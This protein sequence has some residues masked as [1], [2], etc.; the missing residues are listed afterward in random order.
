MRKTLLAL[1]A[2][3]AASPLFAQHPNIQISADFNPNEP[4]ICLDPKNPAR[5]VAG[6]NLN[7]V[8]VSADTGQ[9][10]TAGQLSSPFGVWGDPVL[11]VDT[12]GAFY[13]LHLSNP[14]VGSWIDRIV[15]QKSVDGGQ[16][17]SPGA[18]MGHNGQKAQDKEWIAVDP[19]T[20]HLYVSWTEFDDYGSASPLDSSRILFSKS[21]DGGLNWSEARQLNE[22]SGDCVDSDNT[23]EGAVPSVGPNGEVYVAWAGPAGLVFDRSLDG[24][25]TWL[26]DDIAVDP[27]P[28]GW[29][30]T[31]PGLQ[32]CNGLPV[33]ACDR[34]GGPDH[35]AIYINWSDQRNGAGDTDVWLTKSTDGG[36]TWSPPR[37]VNNDPA[38]RH[39]FLTWMQVDQATGW[40]WFVFYDRRHYTDLR[41][42]VYMA[43]SRDGGTTFQN[44]KVSE[45]PF[46]PSTGQF[47]GDYNNVT[48]HDNV[49]R[50]MWTRMEGLNTSVWTALI[51]V[52]ALNTVGTGPA[53]EE[54]AF[55]VQSG[56]PNPASDEVWIPFRIRRS[57]AVTL[58]VTDPQG[59][60]LHTVFE[61]R[62]YDYGKYTEH[63]P[64]RELGLP[65]GTYSIVVKGGGKVLA[66][67]VVVR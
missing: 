6:A 21:T 30:Y 20:N 7:N 24:G 47:F 4:S 8:Y 23:T 54:A 25:L 14:P 5:I 27:F 1:A 13:F 17:W 33:T 67:R 52:A 16:S 3:L 2:A 49:V 9:T 53:P 65:G 35:G 40:L 60:V 12:A 58:Q 29:D 11:G 63:I 37:R 32:R 61:N 31:V 36:Q 28:G 66:R 26:A 19:A 57:T 42:D 59:R 10:W 55:S 56:Y 51:D 46:I 39:Q 44:F 22:V 34:S 15:C 18:F 41:T 43:V 38:G 62:M 48:V 45:T 64:L 50:P